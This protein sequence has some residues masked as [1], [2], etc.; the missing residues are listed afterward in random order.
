MFWSRSE[1]EP[2]PAAPD[3]ASD[4][5]VHVRVV[6]LHKAYDSSPVLQGL[7]CEILRGQINVIIGG[8]GAGKSVFT[9]QLLRLEQPDQ[10]QILVDGVD[11]VPLDDFALVP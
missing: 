4:D 11:I 5:P 9:R 3:A 1:P 6:D 2:G 10:G 7:S 8:S